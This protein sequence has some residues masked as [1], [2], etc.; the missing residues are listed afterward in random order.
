MCC[1]YCYYENLHHDHKLIKLSDI[2]SLEKENITIETTTKEFN[3]TYQ[4]VRDLKNKIENEIN[5]INNLYEETID[6]L[7]K[8]YLKKHELLLKEE[9]DLKEKLQNEVTKTKEELEINLSEMNNE[10]KICEKINKGIKKLEN[11]EKNMI[12]I[13]SY[14][15]KISDIEKNMKK[16]FS[17]LMK[18]IKFNYDEEK[19]NIIYEKYYFNGIFIPKIIEFKHMSDSSLNI[20]WDIDNINIINCDKNKVKYKVEMRIE[21]EDFKEVYKGNDTNHLINN[22]TS[23]INY[24]FRVCCIYDDLSGEWSETKRI[25]IE[26]EINC[27]SVILNETNRKKELLKKIKE[28]IGCKK[29]ELI[30]RCTRDGST[31]LDFHNNCDNQGETIILIKNE[32]GNI[33]GGYTCYPWTSDESFHSAPN[34]FLFT[35]TNVY[36]T[37]PTKFPSKNDKHEVNHRVEYGPRFGEKDDLGIY[38]DCLKKGG[39]SDFPNSYEDVLEKGNSIFTGDIN[40][41]EKDFKILEFEVFK[42]FK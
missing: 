22:L 42:L 5:K 2:E 27:D 29:M 26:S 31:S 19:S 35:L 32:K 30:F 36:N 28:W 40:N 21:N 3:E 34:S 23:D 25:K 10:I 38:K 14:I 37:E 17:K 33:F 1:L 12:K 9:N 7:T 11:E 6:N 16:L 18:N 13:L 8:S 24:E 39:Y 4:K 41:K 20:F 15:S